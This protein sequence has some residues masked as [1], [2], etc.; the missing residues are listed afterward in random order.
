[1]DLI[2]IIICFVPFDRLTALLYKQLEEPDV[3]EM[4]RITI[5]VLSGPVMVKFGLLTAA[6]MLGPSEG[7]A[8]LEARLISGLMIQCFSLS[9]LLLE[10][11]LLR[12]ENLLLEGWRALDSRFPRI[13]QFLGPPPD[14]CLDQDWVFADALEA[15][16]F[17]SLP[18]HVCGVMVLPTV[19]TI[20]GGLLF[21]KVTSNLRRS[22]L[23]GLTFVA[24]KGVMRV[25]QRQ[26]Q[27]VLKPK[28]RVIDHPE[29]RPLPDEG[30][31]QFPAKTSFFENIRNLI[32]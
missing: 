5:W 3:R 25:Y 7:V 8:L 10:L 28:P 9:T 13:G 19:A 32:C 6:Q 23:G 11:R 4:V 26:Q 12:W 17:P 15:Y 30:R 14:A 27:S 2:W 29:K 31:V 16:S 1:M 22:L 21:P 18:R 20:V 24:V